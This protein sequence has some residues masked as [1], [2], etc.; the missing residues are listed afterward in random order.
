MPMTDMNEARESRPLPPLSLLETRVLGALVEK[1]L[2]VPDT[3][4]LT[5]NALTAACNQKS[6]RDP[7]LAA[8]DSDVQEAVDALR[9]LSLVI[10]SSGGRTMRYAQN[11]KRVLNVPSASVALLATLMLRG[12]QTAGEIRINC[13]RLHRFADI[14]AVQAF[15]DELAARPEG[16]LVAM[17][18]RQAGTREVRWAHLLSGPL[19]AAEPAAAGA[20][21]SAGAPAVSGMSATSVDADGTSPRGGAVQAQGEALQARVVALE[22]EVARLRATVGRLCAEL[23][24]PVDDAG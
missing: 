1:E 10:E 16:A 21:A 8:A 6:S 7:V 4:P 13:E 11:V 2:T 19:A 22:D 15:L 20:P 23:G 14:S 5:L 24:L 18:P 3:Y 9:Q 17:L 12:P